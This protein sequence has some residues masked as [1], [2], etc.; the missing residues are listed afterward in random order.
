MH[1][2]FVPAAKLQ[3]CFSVQGHFYDVTLAA[4]RIS[5]RSVLEIVRRGSRPAHPDAVVI[6]MNPGSS[7]PLAGDPE[8]LNAGQL[9]PV[10]KRLVSARPDTTQYQIMRVMLHCDWDC[11]RVLN[12]SDLRESKSVRFAEQYRRLE[13]DQQYRQHSIFCDARARE[14]IQALRRRPLA[15]LI[16]AWGISLRLDPLIG[17]CTRAIRQHG[18]LV[19]LQKT[20]CSDHYFHPLPALQDDKRAWVADIVALLQD[21][22]LTGH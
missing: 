4:Q 7:K 2:E 18:A 16:C 6:M 21:W 20:D 9:P 12:L 1:G 19:G 22:R 8:Q 14:L 3:N 17:Q 15:P 10:R 5:C 11:V 13:A